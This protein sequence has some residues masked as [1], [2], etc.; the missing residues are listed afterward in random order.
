V[1]E[2][3]TIPFRHAYTQRKTQRL[4]AATGFE[5]PTQTDFNHKC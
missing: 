5:P 4:Y 2:V 3:V 1:E